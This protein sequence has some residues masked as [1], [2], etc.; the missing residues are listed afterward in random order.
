MDVS[1]AKVHDRKRLKRL[2]NQ[3]EENVRM[4]KVLG[5]GVYD[6]RANFNFLDGRHIKPVI[7]IRKASV[8]RSKSPQARK[9]EVI[10]QQ[11]FKLKS[12]SRIHRFGKR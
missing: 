7:R 1:S 11:T 2:V 9:F 10:E 5:D 8:S 6:S 12:W 3:T 4:S